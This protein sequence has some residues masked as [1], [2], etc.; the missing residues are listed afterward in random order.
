MDLWPRVSAGKVTSLAQRFY[1]A[2]EQGIS[3]A[4]TKP[5]APNNGH[6][7]PQCHLRV[8]Q[9]ALRGSLKSGHS[10]SALEAMAAN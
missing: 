6:V 3:A 9:H 1:V 4:I 7:S 8:T 2:D 5:C 10:I